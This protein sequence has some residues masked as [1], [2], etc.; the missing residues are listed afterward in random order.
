ML[1]HRNKNLFIQ[2][3]PNEWVGLRNNEA[4]RISTIE[5]P[6]ERIKQVTQAIKYFNNLAD[7]SWI[8]SQRWLAEIRI[9]AK[10]KMKKHG[11]T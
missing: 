2:R 5:D 10:R 6:E 11:S 9:K 7:P 4:H 3:M 1:A 8:I